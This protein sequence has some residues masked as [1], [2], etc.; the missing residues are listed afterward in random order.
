M[1]Y[2]IQQKNQMSVF[3]IYTFLALDKLVKSTKLEFLHSGASLLMYIYVYSR[4]YNLG[5]NGKP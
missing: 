1:T 5:V 2:Q 4:E 3:L